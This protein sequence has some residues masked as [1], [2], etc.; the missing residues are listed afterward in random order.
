MLENDQEIK[1]VIAANNTS[2]WLR[3]ALKAA[4][5]RDVVDA[6]NDAEVLFTLLDQRAIDLRKTSYI[7]LPG[8]QY[9][10]NI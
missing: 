5:Q 6:A 8:Y 9:I 1:Q 7:A 4:L 3:T 2:T 10:Y